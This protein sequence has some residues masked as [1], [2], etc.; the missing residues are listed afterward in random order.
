MTVNGSIF[1]ALL[2]P[3]HDDGSLN[4]N[5]LPALVDYVLSRGRM[6]AGARAALFRRAANAAEFSVIDLKPVG[7]KRIAIAHQTTFIATGKPA[8]TLF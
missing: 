4:N 1:V 2:T 3:F 5:A 6:D 8:L 7:G